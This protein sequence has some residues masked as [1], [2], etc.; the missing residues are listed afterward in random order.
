MDV[1][2]GPCTKELMLLNCGAGELLRVPWTARIS[3]QS[4]ASVASDSLRPHG[5]SP[6]RLLCPWDSPG[7]ILEWVAI[8]SSRKSSWPRDQTLLS[9]VASALQA[10]SLPLSHWR[11]WTKTTKHKTSSIRHYWGKLTVMGPVA[12]RKI[13]PNKRPTVSELLSADCCVRMDSQEF[14]SCWFLKKIWNLGFL[15]EKFWF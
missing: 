6:T 3:N 12:Y 9:P 2:V 5:L 8:S 7:R 10:D 11:S 15:K 14:Q 4:V 13:Y 1:R